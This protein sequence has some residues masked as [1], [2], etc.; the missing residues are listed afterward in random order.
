MWGGKA[1]RLQ[2]APDVAQEFNVNLITSGWLA[3]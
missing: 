2:P 1:Q 3:K